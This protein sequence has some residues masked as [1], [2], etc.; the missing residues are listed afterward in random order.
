MFSV[1]PMK[2]KGLGRLDISH[3]S[4]PGYVAGIALATGPSCRNENCCG[5][6]ESVSSRGG[7]ASLPTGF[8]T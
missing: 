3:R 4:R 8:P 2:S 6:M 1:L 7:R 5:E